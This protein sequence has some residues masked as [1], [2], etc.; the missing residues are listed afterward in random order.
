[1]YATTRHHPAHSMSIEQIGYVVAL[2]ERIFHYFWAKVAIVLVALPAL[3]FNEIYNDAMLALLLLIGFDFAS[4]IFAAYRSGE[5]IRSARAFRTA[6]KIT[7]YFGLISVVHL[8]ELSYLNFLP[9]SEAM[10]GF[11]AATEVISIVE[12]VG[13]AGYVVPQKLLNRLR[14]F[15]DSK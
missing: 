11:L 13:R 14:E 4:A 5:E 3:F 12:N 10:L 2:V 9:L 6:V 7:V 8:A 1:M 15:R